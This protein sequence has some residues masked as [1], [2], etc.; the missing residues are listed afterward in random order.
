MSIGLAWHIRHFDTH[1]I[2]WHNGGTGGYRTWMGF[3]EKRNLAA[4]VLTNSQQAH[5]DLGF[6]LLKVESR[7]PIAAASGR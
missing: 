1:D 7:D 5:D 2:I 6:E 4:I 3:D